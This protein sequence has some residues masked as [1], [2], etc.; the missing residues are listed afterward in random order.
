MCELSWQAKIKKKLNFGCGCS[1]STEAKLYIGLE[2]TKTLI[3][4]ENWT[5]T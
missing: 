1:G 2:W 3:D 5:T 4:K